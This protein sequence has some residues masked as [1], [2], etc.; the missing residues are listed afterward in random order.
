[1][2]ALPASGPDPAD[3]A[4]FA[5][6]AARLGAQ[7]DID[8]GAATPTSDLREDLGFDSLVMAEAL[9]LLADAGVELPTDLIPELRTL[10][11]LHH[12]ATVL[13]PRAIEVPR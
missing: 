13:A 5:A 6:F 1:V 3:D 2:A 8:L 12:Y 10:G 4:D 11:D 9:L 7:I